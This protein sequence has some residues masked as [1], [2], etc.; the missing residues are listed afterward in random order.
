MMPRS[1]CLPGASGRRRGNHPVT[2]NDVDGSLM[3]NVFP[4]GRL[5]LT[6]EEVTRYWRMLMGTPSMVALARVTAASDDGEHCFG[7]WARV[8]FESVQHMLK[9]P[10]IRI[11]LPAGTRHE[12]LY[13]PFPLT[14]ASQTIGETGCD[15]P[16]QRLAPSLAT[17]HLTYSVP[18]CS[19]LLPFDLAVS[20]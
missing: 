5:A 11:L 14:L 13:F 4:F 1:V 15:R 7:R 9:P 17:V 19:Q 16:L 2:R 12:K 10:S 8:V 3:P 6:I 18:P 20:G